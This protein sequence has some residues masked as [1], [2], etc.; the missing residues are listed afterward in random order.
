MK[1]FLSIPALLLI[2]SCAGTGDYL[3]AVGESL[4][5]T[6]DKCNA[7]YK[8][9]DVNSGC[10]SIDTYY[11]YEYYD[12][13]RRCAAFV[14]NCKC[15]TRTGDSPRDN[16]DRAYKFQ[17]FKKEIL[18]VIPIARQD[19]IRIAELMEQAKQDSIKKESERLERAKQDSSANEVYALISGGA[20]INLILNKCVEH[21]NEFP[22]LRECRSIQDSIKYQKD[23]AEITA[24]LKAN[25]LE[26][27]AEEC[28]IKIKEVKL[29]TDSLFKDLCEKQLVS[30][31]KKLPKNRIKTVALA[32]VYYDNPI[33]ILGYI[34]RDEG[35]FVW[36]QDL[37]W[38][39]VVMVQYSAGYIGK[40]SLRPND[41]IPFS[42]TAIYLGDVHTI[43]FGNVPNYQLLWCGN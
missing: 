13:L 14:E 29:S 40:C 18:R 15:W 19:S 28:G 42:G 6:C 25:K 2:F 5:E 33:E 8:E 35:K 26:E 22:S 37:V 3:K 43:G 17:E 20:E 21:Q 31:V 30:K 7:E 16:E 36:M 27:C 11:K 4:T 1:K 41:R 12:K 23:I 34:F 38:K 32:R 9:L 10:S 39:N 24:L